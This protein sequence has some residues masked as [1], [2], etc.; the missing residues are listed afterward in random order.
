MLKPKIDKD[1]YTKK[2][3]ENF[4]LA[5]RVVKMNQQAIAGKVMKTDRDICAVLN[6][7]P[8]TFSHIDKG[9]RSVTLEMVANMCHHFGFSIQWMVYGT[10]TMKEDVEINHRLNI[11]EG[12]VALLESGNTQKKG[13][14]LQH[15]I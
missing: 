15:K 13:K 7:F 3:T 2:T 11:L 5:V 9:R 12:K 14:T 1:F 10:G 8:S 6:I 4:M